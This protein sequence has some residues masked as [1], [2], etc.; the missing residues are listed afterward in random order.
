MENGSTHA[1]TVQVKRPLTKEEFARLI[2]VIDLTS[3]TGVRNAAL[4]LLMAATGAK[5]SELV[6]KESAPSGAQRSG[7]SGARLGDLNLSEHT[8]TLQSGKT[9]EPRLASLPLNV[10]QFLRSWLA[11]RPQTDSD[12][13]FVTSRGTRL[14]NRYV[15][16]MLHDYGE[17]ARIE[18]DVRPS[19]LRRTYASNLLRDTGSLRALQR[20]L[21]HRHLAS[22]V[23]YLEE[24]DE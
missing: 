11:V 22:A 19:I 17:A 21:G 7:L 23:R 18:I 4:L 6:G 3:A 14:Q 8:L 9:G 15:R 24:E 12:L 20:A 10:E 1:A 2:G 13:I 16:R 5:V